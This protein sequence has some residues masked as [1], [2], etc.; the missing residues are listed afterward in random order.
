MEEVWKNGMV[1]GVETQGNQPC[2]PW[3]FITVKSCESLF[4]SC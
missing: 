2:L 1:L 4:S 3:V